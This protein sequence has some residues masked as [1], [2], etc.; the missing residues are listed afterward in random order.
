MSGLQRKKGQS[1]FLRSPQVITNQ[2]KNVLWLRGREVLWE[3]L[4]GAFNSDWVWWEDES[5]KL[6]EMWN[7]NE[8]LDN[9][10]SN[11]NYYNYS[12]MVGAERV[13]RGIGRGRGRDRVRGE[14]GK[15]GVLEPSKELPW[16]YSECSRGRVKAAKDRITYI[17]VEKAQ[18]GGS[19]VSVGGYMRDVSLTAWEEAVEVGVERKGLTGWQGEQHIKGGVPVSFSAAGWITVSLTIHYLL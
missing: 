5:A 2:R 16:L 3:T 9:S 6:L 12:S 10:N 17:V 8:T 14:M 15:G 7:L 19:I 13:V 4:E 1:L 11:I 18:Y